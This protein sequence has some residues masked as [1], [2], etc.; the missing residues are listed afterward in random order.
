MK[1]FLIFVALAMAFILLTSGL[2]IGR[3][4]AEDK[5]DES[6]DVTT[7]TTVATTAVPQLNFYV[8]DKMLSPATSASDL[9]N[10]DFD[11]CVGYFE[12]DGKTYFF[13]V[14]NFSGAYAEKEM[15]C[16][17][18]WINDLEKKTYGDRNP[19]FGYTFDFE[20]ITM[21]SEK[22]DF[23]AF[24]KESGMSPDFIAVIILVMDSSEIDGVVPLQIAQ[25]IQNQNYGFQAADPGEI[26]GPSADVTPET[27]TE[28]TTAP[29]QVD[30]PWPEEPGAE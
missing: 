20:N 13:Q 7:A 21:L 26:E 4:A 22:D 3:K 9:G 5:P 8:E 10:A 27:T 14:V 23:F 28:V 29:P 25:Y 30:V 15:A 18:I 12:Q 24:P 16:S 2:A 19:T 1:K 6:S 11:G 17:N